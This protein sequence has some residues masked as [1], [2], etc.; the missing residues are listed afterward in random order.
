MQLAIKTSLFAKSETAR[1]IASHNQHSQSLFMVYR[2]EEA[3][4]LWSNVSRIHRIIGG[5]AA[6][7][8]IFIFLNVC[9][10][11]ICMFLASTLFS[12]SPPKN[13]F[14]QLI[15]QVFLR[16]CSR[17]SSAR[18]SPWRSHRRVSQC[19]GIVGALRTVYTVETS[20]EHL[21][22]SQ[23]VRGSHS[24]TASPR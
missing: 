8:K 9:T 15:T 13:A 24:T 3:C 14:A 7:G 10:P 12:S 11:F 23:N 1:E 17:T 21:V 5:R 16:P 2:T 19:R 6:K 4:H 22:L 18:G 20:I